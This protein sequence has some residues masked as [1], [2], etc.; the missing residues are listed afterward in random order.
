MIYY[1]QAH[2]KDGAEFSRDL[3]TR[4]FFSDKEGIKVLFLSLLFFVFNTAYS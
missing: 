4:S 3:R 2:L 1:Y